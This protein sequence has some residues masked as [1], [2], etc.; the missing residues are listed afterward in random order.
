MH[1]VITK[2]FVMRASSNAAQADVELQ[3][4]ALLACHTLNQHAWLGIHGS[5]MAAIHFT[6]Y[7]MHMFV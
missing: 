2:R 7:M 4:H 5:M 1:A 3:A 6:L